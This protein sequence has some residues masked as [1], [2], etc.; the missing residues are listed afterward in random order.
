MEIGDITSDMT[1][2]DLFI[3][4][5]SSDGRY[6]F[7]IQYDDVFATFSL[8]RFF[9]TT[10]SC[11]FELIEMKLINQIYQFMKDFCPTR[12]YWKLVEDFQTTDQGDK[13]FINGMKNGIP[14][15]EISQKFDWLIKLLKLPLYQCS[16]KGKLYDEE[17]N[18]CFYKVNPTEKLSFYMTFPTTVYIPGLIPTP[19]HLQKDS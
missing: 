11:P 16:D 12:V 15:D 8:K 18:L 1:T 6:H 17:H 13:I 10:S 19:A 14:T 9:W 4:H 7:R 5:V 2:P 3:K